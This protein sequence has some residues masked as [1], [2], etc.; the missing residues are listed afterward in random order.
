MSPAY[1]NTEQYERWHIRDCIRCGRRACKA[2]NWEGPIC[3]TCYAKAVRHHGRCR[4]CGTERLLPGRRRGD[5]APICRDCAGIT[6][7]FF[8]AGCGFEGE[9]HGGRLCS[10]CTLAGRL[11]DL[12][13]DGTGR[14][15]P[16]LVPLVD[17][18][19]G[20]PDPLTGLKWLRSTVV[21]GLLGDLAAGRV[22]ITLEALKEL[23][24]QRAVAYLR[25]LLMSCGV[26]PTVD[27]QLL[28]AEALLHQKL[29]ELA[30]DPHFRMLRQFTLWHQ[31]PRLRRRARRG[32]VA[33]GG[34]YYIG[35]VEEA[36]R[37]LAWL[38]E[39]GTQLGDC[40]QA[41]IDLWHAQALA[42]RRQL[43]RPFLLWAKNT[44][45]MPKL[46]IPTTTAGAGK[47]ITQT[48]R[49]ALLR[50]ALTDP[51][52]PLRSRV[53]AALMLLYGQPVA[54]LVRLTIADVVNDDGQV[55]IRLGTP[56]LPVPEPLAGML[57]ELIDNRQNMTTVNPDS[58]WLFPGRRAGQPAHFSTLLQHLRDDLGLPVQ[59]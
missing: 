50:R 30:D 7:D 59:A 51:R 46:G 28:H 2:A 3:R 56:P 11:R 26:L 45:H 10:R 38:D 33:D 58:P 41:D 48:R 32:P 42:H 1:K 55:L 29:T 35:A 13:D 15:H 52:P 19:V 17:S 5:A 4:E 6:R 37:F 40:S 24:N 49:L 14:I 8:C 47:P 36:A 23:P 18:V 44:G 54:R 25:D 12:L 34:R 39:R 57:L 53:A 9:L 27:K 21:R 43:A 22:P 31:L 20:M 16:Q